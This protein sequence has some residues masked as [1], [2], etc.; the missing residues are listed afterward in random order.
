M[1]RKGIFSLTFTLLLSACVAPEENTEPLSEIN[2][3]ELLSEFNSI[4]KSSARTLSE[5]SRTNDLPTTGIASYAGTASFS[6][7]A[8]PQIIAKANLDV[9]FDSGSISG[10]LN[11]FRG[12]DGTIFNGEMRISD[13]QMDYSDSSII[14][15]INGH[16]TSDSARMATVDAT[17]EFDGYFV[18]DN[19]RYVRGAT[20]AMWVTNAGTG[21]EE[22][23][24]M[25]G[26]LVTVKQY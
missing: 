11:D 4:G 24:E 22:H 18:G 2:Y 21:T 19:Y 6:E 17:G 20:S 8:G 5:E 3:N 25:A 26:R 9:D 16:L 12:D 1:L 15:S 10:N 13:G 23:T 14:A 7:H